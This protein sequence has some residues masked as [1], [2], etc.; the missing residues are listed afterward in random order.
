MFEQIL[1]SDA[2]LGLVATGL[3]SLWALVKGSD[4]Y[5]RRRN[6]RFRR[7]VLALEAGVDETYRTYVSAVKDA[8]E[9]GKLTKH[10]QRRARE[11]ARQTAID[12]G[13]TEGVDVLRELGESYI[14][15]WINKL[16]R[17]MKRQ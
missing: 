13:R 5:N 7:A 4:W 1:T 9:D 12:Y 15:M 6:R 2:F 14:D 17:R 11:L 10:E 3:G 16:V 8:R